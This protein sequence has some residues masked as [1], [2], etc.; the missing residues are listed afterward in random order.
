MHTRR[1]SSM[2]G[3]NRQVL[4][5]AGPLLPP[6]F[7]LGLAESPL[8]PP[9]SSSSSR[10]TYVLPAVGDPAAWSVWGDDIDLDIGVPPPLHA[11]WFVSTTV[12]EFVPF[13]LPAD[14]DDHPYRFGGRSYAAHNAAPRD[15]GAFGS[16]AG[17]R[18]W[19]HRII[20]E[21]LGESAAPPSL[22]GDLLSWSTSD[23]DGLGRE[24]LVDGG[25]TPPP[26][27]PPPL[28]PVKT[29]SP[30]P[31]SS[32]QD[33]PPPHQQ[34]PRQP[35]SRQQQQQQTTTNNVAPVVARRVRRNSAQ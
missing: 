9:L 10:G 7:G 35:L 11:P 1:R 8:P 34:P 3:R 4:A 6:Y 25:V 21:G 15:T 13:V 24:C 28:E 33:S 26:G 27:L 20:A 32:Q 14:D 23:R 31:P 17:H 29:S 2:R 22:R 30:P 19:A 16:A 12:P 18:A 5:E